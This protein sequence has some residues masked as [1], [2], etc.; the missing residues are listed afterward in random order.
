MAS[1]PLS[2]RLVS[3]NNRQIINILSYI[4]VFAITIIIITFILY[5]TNFNGKFSERQDD[6]GQF[7]S[8]I[9]GMLGPVLSF[10]A[11]MT[12]VFTV[13]LQGR[14]LDYAREEVE[15]SRDELAAT[16]E[17]LERSADAQAKTALALIEQAEYSAMS[18]RLSALRS[19]LDVLSEE[20]KQSQGVQGIGR[21]YDSYQDL[22]RRKENTAGKI[23]ELTNEILKGKAAK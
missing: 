14:Q 9:G 17:Q 21:T 7:G 19:T 3:L 22:V 2:E 12:L 18:A 8:F 15:N 16:R 13:I 20:I 5:F 1:K 6:W 23:L 10:F 4:M 11:L